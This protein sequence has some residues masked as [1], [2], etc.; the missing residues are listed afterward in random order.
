MWEKDDKI[1]RENLCEEN[2]RKLI[3]L[4]NPKLH[5]FISES[6]E[7]CNPDNVCVCSDSPKDIE[8]I[9]QRAIEYKE[10]MKLA[11]KGHTVHFDGYYDQA[12]DK[13]NTRYLVPEGFD[14]GKNLN[15]V[16]K[17]TGVSEV[18]SY[19]KDSMVGKEMFIRIFCLGPT[20]SPFSIS[21][22][23]L[24]DSAYVAHSEDILYRSGYEQFRKLGDS[25]D[26]FRVLHSAGE[27][28]ENQ[29]SKNVDKRRIYIDF[30]D[31]LV[32]SVN[33]QYAGNTVGF[34]KLC[35]RLAIRKAMR[36]GWMSEHMF[37]MGIQGPKSR[38]T[39]FTGAFPSFCGKT[40]TAMVPGETIIGDDIAYLRRID[41]RVRA[42][43]VENGVFGI[44]QDVNPKDDPLIT[45]ILGEPGEIIFSNILVSDG[46]PYWN[47]D[48]KKHPDKGINYSGKWDKGKKDKDGKDISPSHKN[49]RYT[50]RLSALPNLDK[51]ANDPNGVPVG[52]II[53]GGRDSDTWVPVKQ[54]FNWGH[55]VITMGASLESET[56]AATLGQEGV[57][58][59]QLMSN[60]DFISLRL[61]TYINNYLQFA[62][63][64]E[65]PPLI[66]AVNYFLKGDDGNFLNEK[67]DKKVWLKWMELRIHGE[68][69]S[70]RA[71]TGLFPIYDDL[72]KLFKKVRDK[73]YSKEDYM[74]QFMV[75]VPENLSKLERIC[76]IFRTNVK[77]A[78]QVFYAVMDEQRQRLMAARKKY[79]DYISPFSLEKEE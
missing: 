43:N 31:D 75:R 35:L 77:D 52:G 50:I 76:E 74:K 47:G 73:D 71:P 6:I 45:K 41:G 32:Y 64:M 38:T 62:A 54:S 42:V 19:L 68:V 10:E 9:R 79:D 46:H 26:F 57:R 72:Q 78:P 21:A 30:E 12:R 34:K 28:D 16:D 23:Q 48:G 5:Q 29:V 20:D 65:H 3:E 53:Y 33:T 18:R 13:K 63:G 56:T 24:T 49:A 27:L 61:G 60:L 25:P 14:L 59:F 58:A 22:V 2:Y 11:T 4:P 15:S 51:R 7:L 44:I 66:F 8:Y 17:H 67:L 37:L 39:Y 70:L 36:E 55:G 69:S 1:L 40:S